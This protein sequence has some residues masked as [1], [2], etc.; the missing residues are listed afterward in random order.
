MRPPLQRATTYDI[1]QEQQRHDDAIHWFG[2]MSCFLSWWRIEDFNSGYVERCSTCSSAVPDDVF[3]AYKQPHQT[4]C[5]NCYGTTFEGGLRA[6]Y[7]RPAIWDLTPVSED[8]QKRGEVRRVRGVVQTLSDLD[9]RDGDHIVRSDGTRWCMDQPVWQ[10]ITT[11]M[12][13][14]RGI[15]NRRLR[16][17]VNVNR[18]EEKGDPV[19][20]VPVNLNALALVGWVPYVPHQPHP[21]DQY[22]IPETA[23][24]I[25]RGTDYTFTTTI[26]DD[27][28]QPLDVSS[29]TLT[30]EVR[31]AND[32]MA[33]VVHTIT[34]P[35]LSSAQIGLVSF[36]IP[37]AITSSLASNIANL[38][39]SVIWDNDGEIL[40]LVDRG[41]IP[42]Y[43]GGS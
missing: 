15:I 25:V 12:G 21:L 40:T 17:K 4:K 11:G 23:G 18:E 30:C 28:G 42:I 16:G 39:V 22:N 24:L 41:A 1:D 35:N 7:Y 31:T 9:L 33:P 6:V 10:E 14:Q 2:E 19:W 37:A 26:T 5:P 34:A 3:E 32:S 27:Q 8:V 20:L 36:V 29:W 43:G 38:Y 13:S